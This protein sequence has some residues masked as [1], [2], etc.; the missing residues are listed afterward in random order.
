SRSWTVSVRT[1]RKLSKIWSDRALKSSAIE[2][3]GPGSPREAAGRGKRTARQAKGR[4]SGRHG[5]GE[6]RS[7]SRSVGVMISR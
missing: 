4:R 7:R 6:I 5:P 2:V 3:N 1:G